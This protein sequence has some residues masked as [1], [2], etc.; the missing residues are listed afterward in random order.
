[1]EQPVNYNVMV[2]SSCS[3]GDDFGFEKGQKGTA[4]GFGRIFVFCT[5]YAKKTA[6]QRAGA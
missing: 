6:P 2:Q 4:G 1:M 3:G 5:G